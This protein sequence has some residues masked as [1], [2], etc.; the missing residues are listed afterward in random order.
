MAHEF[1]PQIDL[2]Q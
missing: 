2:L 1:V